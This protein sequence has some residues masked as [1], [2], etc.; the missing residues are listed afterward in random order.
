MNLLDFIGHK[1]Y[2]KKYFFFKLNNYYNI[3]NINNE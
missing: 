1:K 2:I 3:N